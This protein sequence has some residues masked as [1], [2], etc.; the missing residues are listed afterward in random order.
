MTLPQ[1]RHMLGDRVAAKL[2]RL[3]KLAHGHR[4]RPCPFCSLPMTAL[5]MQE[6]PLELDACRACSVVWFDVPTYESLPQLAAETTNTLAMQATE[7]I[8]LNK[9]KELKE[10]EEAERKAAR[11]K[12]PIH[13]L[14][15]L[16][17]DE[18]RPR[19][20]GDKSR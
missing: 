20:E 15:G 19:P 11:K 12:R 3:L 6:P 17:E 1:I 14:L 2:L 5:I 16:E 7:I 4:N 18:K 8:A 13:R 10:R 9:L